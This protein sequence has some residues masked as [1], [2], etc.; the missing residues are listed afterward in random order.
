M[1]LK[2]L[3]LLAYAVSGQKRRQRS[4][5]LWTGHIC[6]GVWQAVVVSCPLPTYP[7]EVKPP[8]PDQSDGTPLHPE[9]APN[10]P[11]SLPDSSSKPAAV[12]VLLRV[13]SLV[14]APAHESN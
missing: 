11:K 6:K 5:R 13:V 1:T 7:P 3:S 10:T 8:V 2:M 9:I 14:G 4:P 12:H